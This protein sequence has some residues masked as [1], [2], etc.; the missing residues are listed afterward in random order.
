[1]TLALDPSSPAKVVKTATGNTAATGSITYPANT[2]LLAFWN[3]DTS[4]AATPTIAD[5]LGLTWTVVYRICSDTAGEANTPTPSGS[6]QSG[7][8]KCWKA[9][10]P[11]S[12]P[13]GRTITVT[14]AGAGG[15][16]KEGM[17]VVKAFTDDGGAPTVGAVATAGGTGSLPTKG[18]NSTVANS[19]FWASA[20]DWNA[21]GTGS[22]PAG[23]T[24]TDTNDTV[25]DSQHVWKQNSNTPTVG[26]LVTMNLSGPA[27]QTWNMGVV[28]VLPNPAAGPPAFSGFGVPL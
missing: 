10:T 13:A 17:L 7:L 6:P 27:G 18:V 24:V 11:A 22:A 15:T 1:M 2:L 8:S 4:G 20:N 26:T 5:S 23:Q 12:A 14:E 16:G 9:T 3:Q 28:E 25:N 21:S 19:W